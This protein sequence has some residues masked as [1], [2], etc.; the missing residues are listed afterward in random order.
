MS[1]SFVV[2]SSF[3]ITDKATKT[4]TFINEIIFYQNARNACLI[5]K[6]SV[7]YGANIQTSLETMFSVQ[8]LA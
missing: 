2:S 5:L 1:S 3:G 6:I 4:T 7:K 8:N